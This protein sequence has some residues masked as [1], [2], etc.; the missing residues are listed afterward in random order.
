MILTGT[1]AN[2]TSKL[3]AAIAPK[4]TPEST[5]A[6]AIDPTSTDLEINS[7]DAENNLRITAG[8]FI[9]PQVKMDAVFVG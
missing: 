7:F 4:T 5:N 3:R 1:F 9:G 6:E 8:V 2:T